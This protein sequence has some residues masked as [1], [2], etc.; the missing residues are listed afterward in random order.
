[1]KYRV[2]IE[3]V[4]REVDVTVTPGGG[5]NVS[6]DGS[7]VEADVERL[8]DGLSLILDGKVFDLAFGGKPE[9]M[10]VASRESRAV[11]DVQSERIRARQKKKGGLG[12]SGKEIR[13]PMPGRVVKLLVAVGDEVKAGDPCVV[14]EAMKM[15][16]EL[17]A[18][19]DGTVKALHA[20]E[21]ASVEGQALLVSFT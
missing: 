14:V 11:V 4:E 8:P 6:M 20:D 10:D 1:M 2:S 13:S 3:G 7:P 5:V 16:N 9:A 15:E 18:P 12:A 19:T 21:G 17:R